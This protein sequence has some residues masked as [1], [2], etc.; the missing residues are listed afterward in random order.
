[1]RNRPNKKNIVIGGSG[2]IGSELCLFLK[3][4]GEDVLNISKKINS[5]LE[6]ISQMQCDVSDIET[7]RNLLKKGENVYILIG[8]IYPEFSFEKEIKNIKNILD[9][10]DKKTVK[11]VFYFS[12]V[13]LYGETEKPAGEEYLANPV[14]EYGKFKLE[15][16]KII[17][18]N[19]RKNKFIAGILR[20]ANVYGKPGNKGFVG[21]LMENL[22]KGKN[23][24]IFLTGDGKQLRDYIFIDDVIDMAV[25]IKD[26]LADSDVINIATG[27]SHSLIEVVEKISNVSGKEIKYEIKNDKSVGI[28]ISLI[29]NDKLI[30]RYNLIPKYD[31]KKGLQRTWEN[32]RNY[33]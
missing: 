31:L 27:K 10:L 33:E 4:R 21:I 29:S 6:N 15:C 5:R 16:E 17:L 11:K 3:K 25:N 1:M 8:Q 13:L 24:K 26:K 28:K 12:S 14:D 30:N 9:C 32:Y 19:A 18:K 22:S 20:L 2:F 7:L 23:E